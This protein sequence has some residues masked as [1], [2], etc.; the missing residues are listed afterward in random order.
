MLYRLNNNH[1][2]TQTSMT[3]LLIKHIAKNFSVFWFIQCNLKNI[4]VLLKY[5]MYFLHLTL[6]TTLK[7]T[8]ASQK[9]DF[10]YILHLQQ[11]RLWKII[12][13]LK[14]MRVKFNRHR[15]SILFNKLIPKNNCYLITLYIYFKRING[16]YFLIQHIFYY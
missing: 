2:F 4:R 9:L 13:K 10:G 3:F 11:P 14:K 15:M 16:F 12:L 8:R 1:H 5:I 7:M 6:C